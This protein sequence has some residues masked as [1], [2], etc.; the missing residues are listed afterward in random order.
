MYMNNMNMNNNQPMIMTERDSIVCKMLLESYIDKLAEIAGN[1]LINL[2]DIQRRAV[3][4]YI[5]EPMELFP[6]FYFTF[7]VICDGRNMT[8]MPGIKSG[9]SKADIEAQ[10]AQI[11]A[12]DMQMYIQ[13]VPAAEL[14]TAT[15]R[16]AELTSKNI[17]Q[18]PL[19]QSYAQDGNLQNLIK[20]IYLIDYQS[21]LRY[22]MNCIAVNN[23]IAPLKEDNRIDGRINHNK[24]TY[25]SLTGTVFKIK[26]DISSG[27]M[28][29]ELGIS[30]EVNRWAK[31]DGIFRWNSI[32][33]GM[34]GMN[35]MGFS[36]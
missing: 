35:G 34:N 15:V 6:G 10:I 30:E 17:T 18:V 29:M 23:Y 5:D 14:A 25:R 24:R 33:N 1:V 11:G 26:G 4:V 27:T 36:Y 16:F 3:T 2:N 22:I 32:N 19:F 13:K 28:F 7:Y 8:T 21:I 31:R 9:V 12:M 20:M